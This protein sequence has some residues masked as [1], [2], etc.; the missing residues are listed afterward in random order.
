MVQAVSRWPFRA[1]AV[2]QS[3]ASPCEI[4]DVR[5]DTG[6]GFSPVPLFSPV[7]IIP[8]LRHIY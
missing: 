1:E 2:V 7:S 8:P 3:Q 6:T 5:S 4:C